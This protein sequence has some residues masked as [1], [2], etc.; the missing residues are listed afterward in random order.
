MKVISIYG[1][2]H[3][4]FTTRDF[5]EIEKHEAAHFG[6]SVKA[7]HKYDALLGFLHFANSLPDDEKVK[8]TRKQTEEKLTRFERNHG[9]IRGKVKFATVNTLA[10]NK[11]AGHDNV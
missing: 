6:L 2:D 8:E 5:A 7:K 11:S 4:E 9:L 10:L 3:C 1:C